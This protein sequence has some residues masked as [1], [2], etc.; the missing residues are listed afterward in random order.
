M[1]PAVNFFE[2]LV[3]CRGLGLRSRLIDCNASRIAYHCEIPF[4]PE[5]LLDCA[6]VELRGRAWPISAFVNGKFAIARRSS[7]SSGQFTASQAN[8]YSRA[9]PFQGG[10]PSSFSPLDTICSAASGNGHC[11]L[12]AT[13][14]LR[15]SHR[16]ASSSSD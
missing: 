16:S 5:M 6:E 14:A 12:S 3:G 11:S 1:R 13:L 2:E 8:R 4:A 10:P 9:R 15:S 7:A